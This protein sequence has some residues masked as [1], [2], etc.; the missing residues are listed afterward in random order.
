MQDQI[1]HQIEDTLR[2]T[3]T[4]LRRIAHALESLAHSSNP[5]FKTWLEV[6]Q[7]NY[8]AKKAAKHQG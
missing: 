2:N 7:A 3:V 8:E 4:E 6:N 1:A 5:A